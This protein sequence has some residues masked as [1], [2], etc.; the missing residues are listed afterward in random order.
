MTFQSDFKKQKSSKEIEQKIMPISPKRA[1]EWLGN[2]TANRPLRNWWV[3]EL[4]ERMRKGQWKLSPEPIVFTRDGKMLDGQHRSWAI[5]ES[6]MT[7]MMSVAIVE[8]DSVF[9]VLDQGVTRSNSDIL[10]VPTAV[11]Q[12]IHYLH[13]ISYHTKRISPIELKP[14]LKTEMVDMSHYIH[15]IVKPKE[16]RFKPAIFRAA[17]ISSVLLNKIERERAM[18]VYTDLSHMNLQNWNRMMQ[19]LMHLIDNQTLAEKRN[20]SNAHNN[21]FFRA[22]YF[23]ENVDSKKTSI[24]LLDKFKNDTVS[25]VRNMYKSY[26]SKATDDVVKN[27]K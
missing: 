12:P 17:L 2:N 11:L 1:E 3:K 13:R 24:R 6:G 15:E 4:A 21:T 26:H 23:F 14:L 9:E 7:V 8:D 22:M 16:K 20:S 5:I 19:H 27:F 18:E 25:S 10:S